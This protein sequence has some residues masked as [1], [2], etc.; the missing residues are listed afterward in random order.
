MASKGMGVISPIFLDTS[1]FHL[2]HQISAIPNTSTIHNKN[3]KTKPQNSELS[4][5]IKL[6]LPFSDD[7]AF[8]EPNWS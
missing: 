8:Q 6:V 3:H 4:S 2:Y 1:V 5:K 7:C